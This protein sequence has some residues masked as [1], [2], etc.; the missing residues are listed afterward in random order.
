MIMYV[1]MYMI[2]YGSSQNI[3]GNGYGYQDRLFDCT[4]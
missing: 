1:E 3:A 2:Y 4:Q